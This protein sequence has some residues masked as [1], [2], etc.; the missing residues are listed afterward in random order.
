MCVPTPLISFAAGY[1]LGTEEGVQRTFAQSAKC[2]QRFWTGLPRDSHM[3][4]SKGR[5]R[6][7]MWIAM[8]T[9][10]RGTSVCARLPAHHA[11]PA[12][13]QDLRRLSKLPRV[14]TWPRMSS[15]L[16]MLR[17]LLQRLC[18]HGRGRR[19]WGHRRYSARPRAVGFTAGARPGEDIA[20]FFCSSAALQPVFT[21]VVLR[22]A[23]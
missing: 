12:S 7:S 22:Q 16:G 5:R 8:N 21:G 18:P 6:F 10:E 19:R 15:Y 23:R 17:S 14:E 4:D 1:D 3:N 20:A 9:S 2:Y 11:R 13:P